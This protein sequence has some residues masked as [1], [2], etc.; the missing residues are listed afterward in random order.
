MNAWIV[1]LAAFVA[2]AATVKADK[3]IVCYFGSWAVYRQDAGKFDIDDI[4]PN[5]CTHIIY[6]FIG[7]NSDGNVR[8]L[9]PWQDLPDDYGKNGFGRFNN[10]RK[11]NTNI[12]TMIAIGGWNEGSVKYSN[13]VANPTLRAKFVNS[14][15]Q[16]LKKYGFDG[17]DVDWEYPNQRGGK[18]ADKQNY[19]S[20]LKEL[21]EKFDQHGYILS[22][23][24]GAAAT[25]ARQSYII[26]EMCKYLNFINLMTYDLHGSWESTTGIN[27]PLYAKKGAS[28]NN[29]QFT[30]DASVKYWLSQGAPPEKL[31]L[32]V[33]FYGRSFT[34]KNPQQHDVGSPS[35]GAGIAGPYTNEPGMLGYNEICTELKNGKWNIVYDKEQRAPYAYKD[36]QWV[37]Y[38]DVQSLKEKAEYAKANGLGGA[39]L[40]SIETD[41]FHGA[42]GEKYPLLK[43]LNNVLRNGPP[44][45]STP[46]TPTKTTTSITPTK[47]TTS[48]T[49][50]KTTTPTDITKPTNPPMS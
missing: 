11:N 33:P 12:K 16:F 31:I 13:V 27:S 15:V 46:T 48:I 45:T 17:F 41:D 9:D 50:T 5:L 3:K 28:A 37:G 10:L 29:A 1:F 43:I 35:T 2:F 19:I 4:D 30:V 8:I 23:A 21:R 18:P 7:L 6:T 44:L 47:T 49:P 14:V 20:L 26:S 25:S 32:G 22:A 42:C 36:N 34:L 40:W 39:M 24:V 38:D